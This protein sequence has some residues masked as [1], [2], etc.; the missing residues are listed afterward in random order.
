MY[1]TGAKG[2]QGFEL[3]GGAE[4]SVGGIVDAIERDKGH[5]KPW[6]LLLDPLS[7]ALYRCCHSLLRLYVI[8]A[9]CFVW[10]WSVGIES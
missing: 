3:V 1:F 7:I 4:D 9:C 2:A 5:D 10:Q 8:V 6:P